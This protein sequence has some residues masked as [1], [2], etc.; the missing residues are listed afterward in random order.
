MEQ[1]MIEKTKDYLKIYNQ[2]F[3]IYVGFLCYTWLILLIFLVK[4]KIK[5]EQH[6]NKNNSQA[7][8]N[9]KCWRYF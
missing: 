7:E 1:D 4:I 6:N 2:I 8:K 9:K 3:L 5:E